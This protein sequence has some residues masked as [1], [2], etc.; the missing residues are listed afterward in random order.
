[1]NKLVKEIGDRGKI[2]S[3]VIQPI[4]AVDFGGEKMFVSNLLWYQ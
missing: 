2:D 3:E 4:D 1:M